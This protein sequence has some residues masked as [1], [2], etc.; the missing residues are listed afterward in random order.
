MRIQKGEVK[1][2]GIAVGHYSSS[3]KK[4]IVS[5]C[6]ESITKLENSIKDYA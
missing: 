6:T 5:V 3:Q 4:L 2:V 1:L